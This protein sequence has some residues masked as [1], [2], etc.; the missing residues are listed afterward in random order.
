MS[1]GYPG[2]SREL[3]LLQKVQGTH[4]QEWALIKLISFIRRPNENKRKNT[5][6]KE[7]KIKMLDVNHKTTYIRKIWDIMSSI[8][9]P[10]MIPI[11]YS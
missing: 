11:R 9:K 1:L 10:L 4:V 3:S 6:R 8:F 5:K 7:K 2:Y